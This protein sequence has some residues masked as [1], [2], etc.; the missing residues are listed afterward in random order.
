MA[1]AGRQ[2]EERGSS[3]SAQGWERTPTRSRQG[4]FASLCD[5]ARSTLD[6]AS[7]RVCRSSQ[8]ATSQ[9]VRARRAHSVRTFRTDSSAAPPRGAPR[10]ALSVRKLAS[11]SP[12]RT[13]GR[14]LGF[15]G[16]DTPIA[17]RAERPSPED[18]AAQL[19]ATVTATRRDP[20]PCAGTPA[21]EHPWNSADLGRL[22]TPPLCLRIRR[23]GVRIPRGAHW[24]RQ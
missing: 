14:E 3:S 17:H 8:A 21:D 22:Q 18:Q 5:R 16:P 12:Q 20:G 10:A 15:D 2:P 9:H 11:H 7:S 23:L 1:L 6:S 4:R 13:T 24:L 19:T